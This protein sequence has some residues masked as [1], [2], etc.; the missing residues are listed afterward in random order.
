MSNQYSLAYLT[1]KELSPDEAVLVAAETGYDMVGFRL[2]PAGAEDPFAILTDKNLQQRTLSAMNETDIKLADI[3][4]VRINDSF[5][6]ARFDQFLSVGAELGAKHVLVAGDDLDRNRLIENYGN[7]CK[8]AAEFGMSADLE[9]MPWT[10]VKNI[11]DAVEVTSAVNYSN[12]AILVDALHYDRSESSLDDLR[13]I[14]PS[15]INYI[16]VCDAPY[17]KNPT[18]DQLI[19]NAR[20]ER[21]LPGDGDIDIASMLR[22]L[23]RE[24]V[25]SI[26][27]PRSAEEE[28]ISAK[29]R[30]LEALKRTKNLLREI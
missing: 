26:E 14:D 7:F 20:G 24:K 23:P 12:A 5:N 6:L 10:A 21:L 25:I 19:H 13:S 15:R 2:L 29:E 1:T 4:I 16:Q 3:E 17:I 28:T 30:A 11:R 18:L 22:A 27:I 9:P 8:R